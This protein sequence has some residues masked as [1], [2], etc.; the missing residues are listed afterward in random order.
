[1]FASILVFILLLKYCVLIHIIW[2]L[3]LLYKLYISILIIYFYPNFDSLPHI[4]LFSISAIYSS[5]IY[6]FVFFHSCS[7]NYIL[8]FL[9]TYV[10]IFCFSC[11]YVYLYPFVIYWHCFFFLNDLFLFIFC[12]NSYILFSIILV[13]IHSYYISRYKRGN[14]ARDIVITG[15]YGGYKYY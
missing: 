5:L 12:F 7:Y 1:M 9:F 2:K 6:I 14:F 8:L 15:L 13:F 3:F 10:F 4:N 11:S